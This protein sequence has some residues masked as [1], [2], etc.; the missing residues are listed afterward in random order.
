MSCL[1][2]GRHRAQAGDRAEGSGHDHG[3][4]A[5]VS[6]AVKKANHM[7]HGMLAIIKNSFAVLNIFT[8]PLLFKAIV[9]PL[10]EYGNV[11]W[12]HSIHWFH[13][14]NRTWKRFK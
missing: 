10:L 5:Q 9:R 7:Q 8:L 11:I 3:P 13:T 1:R 4:G 2:D 12:A 6:S 14:D